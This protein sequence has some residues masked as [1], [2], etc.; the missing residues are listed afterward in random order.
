VSFLLNVGNIGGR[1]MWSNPRWLRL[2]QLM[3]VPPERPLT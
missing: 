2:A 1:V 3:K